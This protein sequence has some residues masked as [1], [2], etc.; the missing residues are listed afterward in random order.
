M[1]MNYSCLP[2]PSLGISTCGRC[3]EQLMSRMP[4]ST[5]VG[6]PWKRRRTHA[7]AC[8]RSPSSCLKERNRMWLA[9]PTSVARRACHALTSRASCSAG[10]RSTIL[11]SPSSGFRVDGSL[12][13]ETTGAYTYT[14]S[15]ATRRRRRT[16]SQNTRTP[17]CASTRS[18]EGRISRQGRSTTPRAFGTA[19][20]ARASTRLPATSARST[21]SQSASRARTALRCCSRARATTRSSCGTRALL[22]ASTLS[23][24][25]RARSLASEPTAGS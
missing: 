7:A 23:S 13:G 19:A 9:T 5:S 18:T 6:G 16:L 3:G 20:R 4:G 25:T 15:A 8:R 12:L 21:A 11:S 14:P 24:A 17:S 1:R 22:G 10:P 2:D